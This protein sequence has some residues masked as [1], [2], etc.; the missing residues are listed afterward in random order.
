LAL[1]DACC[2]RNRP[3]C[4]YISYIS[5]IRFIDQPTHFA[6]LG[7]MGGGTCYEGLGE[8]FTDTQN[9]ELINRAKLYCTWQTPTYEKQKTISFFASSACSAPAVAFIFVVRR[10]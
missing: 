8:T 7:R 1:S 5:R 3:G 4:D 10:L 9:D 2:S 6:F